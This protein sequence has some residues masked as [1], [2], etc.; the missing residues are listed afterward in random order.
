MTD[1][2]NTRIRDDRIDGIDERIEWVW[3]VQDEGAWLGPSQEFMAIYQ[4]M[5]P[6]IRRHGVIVQAGG[7]CGMYPKLFSRYFERV[8]T[9]EPA[10]L[11]WHCLTQNCTEPHITA[12]NAAVGEFDQDILLAIADYSN[13]GTNTVAQDAHSGTIEVPQMRV[14]SLNLEACDAIQ[15]DIEGYEISALLGAIDTIT[16]FKPVI[17]LETRNQNDAAHHFLYSIGYQVHSQTTNDTQ[18]SPILVP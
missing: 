15:L 12:Y 10:P 14:D 5:R 8:I 17:S 4:A 2:F 13:V 6:K 7:C 3:P 9:F 16:K 18:F 11:N 1:Q